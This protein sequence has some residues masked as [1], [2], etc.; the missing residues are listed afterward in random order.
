LGFGV[1]KKTA[2]ENKFN[3]IMDMIKHQRKRN[4]EGK[5]KTISVKI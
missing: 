5:E 3:S 1:F 2:E 4:G